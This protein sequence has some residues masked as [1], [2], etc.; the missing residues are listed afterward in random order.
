[1]NTFFR[2][3]ARKP[4]FTMLM[5]L[6]L[7]LSAALSCIGYSALTSAKMQQEEISG[8]YTTIALPDAQDMGQL[9]PDDLDKALQNRVFA[10]K[11]ARE[12]PQLRMI[13]RRC[14]LSAHIAGSKSL[15]SSRVD[16]SEYNIAFDG[17]CYA[18]AVFA[19]RCDN[20]LEQPTGGLFQYDA[21]FSVEKIVCLSDAYKVFPEPD[22]IHIQTSVREADGATPFEAGKTYLVFGLY[23]DY[24]VVQSTDGYRQLTTDYRYIRP[25]PEIRGDG[26]T[27]ENG[28]R[29]GQSYRFPAEGQLPWVCEYTGSAEDFL[30][31][32]AASVWR[33]EIIPLCQL[34]HESAAVILTDC[35]ESMY[36]FNTGEES[37]LS[38][39][40]FTDEEYREGADVCILSAAYAELNGLQLG[41]TVRLDYYDSSYSEYVNGA[42]ANSLF[43][44]ADPGPYC[45]RHYM[46]PD[47]A[48]GVCKEYTVVGLYTGARFAFGAYQFN[49][50]TIFVPKASVPNTEEYE[51]WASSRLD[52]FVLKNGSVE[53]FEACMEQQGLGGQ[54]LYFDQGFSSMQESLAALQANAVRLM[55]VGGGVFL[56]VS[57]LFL[58]LNFR[59]MK[60]VVRGVR[61]LGRTSKVAF[62]EMIMVLIPLE[63]LAILIGTGIAAMLFDT[64][65][66][67][68]LSGTLTLQP[69][70][71]AVASA[72]AFVFLAIA[73]MISTAILAN[74]KLMNRT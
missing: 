46:S 20:V 25:F 47:N 18:L 7:A 64:V 53:A 51:A 63:M 72:A 67:R 44:S 45:Q 52:S 74:R 70:A 36:T 49:A 9:S 17:E 59:R 10:D 32:D 34:N 5:V 71:M 42:L 31:S 65:T 38:G 14:L 16:P 66:E 40:F 23:Q 37:L 26:S 43:A 19:L 6:L 11:A 58:F 50:D 13:D 27:L 56:L 61:L 30:R 35:M 12:A 60:P 3:A 4:F 29:S 15:S 41:D 73:T 62:G 1:M 68:V 28:I 55:A 21:T 24:R 33:E 39:R 22:L 2:Q 54:F 57:A 48:I 69:G 8:G